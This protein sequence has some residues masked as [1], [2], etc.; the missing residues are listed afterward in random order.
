MPGSTRFDLNVALGC[1]ATS[2][3]SGAP[4]VAVALRVLRVDAL[5]SMV[6]SALIVRTSLPSYS[7]VPRDRPELA[8]HGRD[9]HV[10]HAEVCRRVAAVDAPLVRA[11]GRR[12]VGA[13][14]R[15]AVADAGERLAR[16]PQETVEASHRPV[17]STMP[18][19]HRQTAR[20]RL[21]PGR[22][23]TPRKTRL[24]RPGVS[25]CH[26]LQLD[27]RSV[28]LPA[29]RDPARRRRARAGAPASTFRRSR[30]LIASTNTENPI[31]K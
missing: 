24:R 4:Q 1:L 13:W 21:W 29:R 16:R 23:W 15:G 5:T 25:G 19:E 31:A 11:E 9:H 6:T 8:A 27:W 14:R 22:P 7:I 3:K 18:P 26:R 10:A 30:R 2:K 17:H 20:R 12:P 28:A